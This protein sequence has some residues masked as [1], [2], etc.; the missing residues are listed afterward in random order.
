MKFLGGSLG[1]ILGWKSGWNS[2]VELLGKILGW[3]S[4]VLG[5]VLG[6]NS[7]V[8]LRENQVCFHGKLKICRFVVIQVE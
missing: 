8:E 3:N 6:W 1:G 2:W 4:A 7:G 5:G